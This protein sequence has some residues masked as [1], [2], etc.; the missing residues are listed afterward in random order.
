V[1]Y[2]IGIL[3]L[4]LIG[5]TRDP[6]TEEIR[7]AAE[8]MVAR[9]AKC[10]LIAQSLNTTGEMHD[11]SSDPYCAIGLSSGP[12]IG[13]SIEE[14]NAIDRYLYISEKYGKSK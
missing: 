4:G 11:I 5:C 12:L 2:L 10:T 9:N 13:F 3:I 8:A 7:A 14:M 6:S 1:K